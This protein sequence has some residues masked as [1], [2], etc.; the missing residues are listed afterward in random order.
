M[1]QINED[2][3]VT[4]GCSDCKKPFTISK[5]EQEFFESKGFVLPKRCK[6]CR[7]IRRQNNV[8]VLRRG[9]RR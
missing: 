2:G 1:T 7:I 6:P 5:E 3:S 8:D 4:I 9:K